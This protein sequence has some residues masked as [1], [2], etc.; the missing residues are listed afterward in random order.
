MKT[1]ALVIAVLGFAVTSSAVHAANS[2]AATAK[3]T[4]AVV[5]DRDFVPDR[6]PGSNIGLPDALAERILRHLTD[7]KRFVAVER[8]SLRRVINEQRF[9][10]QLKQTFLDRTLEKAIGSMD[11]MESYGDLAAGV[12]LGASLAPNPVGHGVGVGAGKIGTTGAL[13]NFNDI[14]KDFLDLGKTTGADLLV[15]GTIERL[16]RVNKDTP[17]PFSKEGKS[18]R[19]NLVSAR[20]RLRLIDTK[21]GT[22]A[23]ASSLYVQ[24]RQQLF[25][26]SAPGSEDLTIFD[27]LGRQAAGT[28][29]DMT[30][31]A[32]ITGTS[33]LVISRGGNDG[34][35]KAD[36]YEVK[37][38]GKEVK[39]DKGI[40]LGRLKEDIGRVSVTQ[41]EDTFAVVE[42]LSSLH[43]TV[44][45]LVALE[46]R[47][48]PTKTEIKESATVSF[49][50]NT[51]PGSTPALPRLAVG[52]IKV[53]SSDQKGWKDAPPVFTETLKSKLTQTRRFQLID[54]QE[55]D[56]LLEEQLAQSLRDGRGLPSP[57]GT[58]KGADYVL[59]GLLSVFSVEEKETRLP[60]SSRTFKN[61]LGYVEGNMHLTDARSGD[62]QESRKVSISVPIDTDAQGSRVLTGLADAYA[63]Q[64]VINIMNAVYPIKIVSIGS[65]RTLYLN[66]GED[67]GLG[68]DEVLDAYQPGAAVSD[69]D[70]GRKLGQQELLVGRVVVSEVEDKRSK[71]RPADAADLRA[72]F[73]LKRTAENKPRRTIDAGK[74]TQ[75]VRTGAT[76]PGATLPGATKTGAA[77]ATAPLEG[78]KATLAVGLL[79]IN[80]GA[81][82]DGF[83]E[84]YVERLTN[85]LITKFSHTNRFSVMER[86]E[87]DQVLDEKTLDAITKGQT[88]TDLVKRLVSADYLVHGDIANFYT[89]VER[90]K[91]P[92]T[93]REQVNTL[94]SAEGTLRVV[95]VHAGEIVAADR[96]AVYGVWPSSSLDETAAMTSLINRFSTEAVNRIQLRIYP[97]KV[98]GFAPDGDVYLNRGADSGLRNGDL[99][100][101]MRPGVNMIDPDTKRSFGLSE[102]QVGQLKVV[103]IEDN[104]ARARMVNGGRA[105]PGDILR[106]PQLNP[107]ESNRRT[108]NQ[109]KW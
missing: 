60:S 7:S 108:V 69:P 92:Y 40:V 10:Q 78:Q 53:A 48:E 11:K 75:P 67:G 90:K 64:T 86:Q 63:D 106:Q 93:D 5:S 27:H 105:E 84:G 34:V 51:D 21:A 3:A 100:D 50:A 4:I 22:V 33:P 28:I 73:I 47:G 2:S 16:D 66:R 8:V 58:L 17:V 98:I 13:S 102:T 104:R 29:L 41:V 38:E 9:G 55:V 88:V 76:L 82:T 81:R 6:I 62:I 107:E 56:Q 91:I 18:V 83:K 95:D 77:S 31:P 46:V 94:G 12:G 35:R 70:D 89:T 20:L 65:D 79:K 97:I 26:G 42:P 103:F 109:P 49:P 74:D 71:A 99:F 87:V 32:R 54:R 24:L 25:A 72:G 14:L 68:K 61:K 96:I 101:V 37:R 85:E 59:Y 80:R 36:V 30:F 57:V 19:E 43:A 44:G 39:D 52:K 15:V 45:D 23:G 1:S